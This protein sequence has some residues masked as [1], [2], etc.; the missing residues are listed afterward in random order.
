MAWRDAAR[1]ALIELARS[2][3]PFT[4]DDLIAKVGLPDQSHAPNSRNS[5]VGSAFR[6]AAKERLIV[7]DGRLVPSRSSHR[8]GGGVRVWRGA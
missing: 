1:T 3:Q 4:S 6:A 8:K 7:S 5:A 2:G